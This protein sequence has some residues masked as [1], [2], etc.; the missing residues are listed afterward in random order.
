ML[1]ILF[2]GKVFTSNPLLPEIPCSRDLLHQRSFVDKEGLALGVHRYNRSGRGTRA[3]QDKSKPGQEQD[4]TRAGQDRAGQGWAGLG[5]AG[6]GRTRQGRTRQGRTRQDKAGQDKAGQGRTRQGRTRQDKAGQD[7]AGQGRAGQG[8][9]RQDK[10]GQD[11]VPAYSINPLL[12]DG[13]VYLLSWQKKTI[14]R[15]CPFQRLLIEDERY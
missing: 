10:A 11:K 13:L 8:R 14:M 7:K 15:V 5:R 6:Q 9:T 1:E 2:A 3:N 12:P 4:K